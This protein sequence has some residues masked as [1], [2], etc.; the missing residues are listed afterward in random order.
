MA[1][2]SARGASVAGGASQAAARAMR[3]ASARRALMADEDTLSEH[4]LHGGPRRLAHLALELRREPR[5]GHE[6]PLAERLAPAREED[7]RLVVDRLPAVPVADPER[8]ETFRNLGVSERR[9]LAA[10]G[11]RDR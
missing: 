11:E 1:I 4:L 3:T 6:P 8:S 10:R 7:E 2:F 9:G 5:E